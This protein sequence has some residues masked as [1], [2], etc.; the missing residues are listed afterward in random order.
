MA[1]SL[2]TP[3]IDIMLWTLIGVITICTNNTCSL[4]QL[5][6][7]QQNTDAPADA[8][9]SQTVKNDIFYVVLSIV[10]KFNFDKVLI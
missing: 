1:Q 7:C 3:S 10:Y 2:F 4:N 9:F 5:A 6:M 8:K